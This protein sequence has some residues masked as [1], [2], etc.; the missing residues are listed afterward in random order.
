VF[1]EGKYIE[2]SVEVITNDGRH[3]RKTIIFPKGHPRNRLTYNEYQE[4]FRRTA[5]FVL[6]PDKVE[7]AME[8][9]LRL[10]EVANVSEV[11]ELMY[12]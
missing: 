6:K 12:N 9:I 10:E 3:I 4:R 7:T 5:S 8:K 11:T 1:Q 2:A